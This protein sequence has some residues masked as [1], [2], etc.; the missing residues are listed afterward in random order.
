MSGNDGTKSQSARWFGGYQPKAT[1]ESAAYP[2]GATQHDILKDQLNPFSEIDKEAD[3]RALLSGDQLDESWKGIS[4][5]PDGTLVITYTYEETENIRE[6]MPSGSENKKETDFGPFEG[7]YL[8][9]MEET[10]QKYMP[11]TCNIRFEKNKNPE[12]AYLSIMTADLSQYDGSG[13]GGYA[14]SPNPDGAILIMNHKAMG[15]SPEWNK[16]T[17][18]HEL[19]HVAGLDHGFDGPYTLPSHQAN[20]DFSTMNYAPGKHTIHPQSF[21]TAGL[22]ALESM[23][24]KSQRLPETKTHVFPQRNKGWDGTLIASSG[25]DTIKF[26][27]SILNAETS[28]LIDLRAGTEHLSTFYDGK[29]RARNSEA[30]EVADVTLS[31]RSHIL[32]GAENANQ[33]LGGRGQ[34]FLQG[35]GGNDTISG[36]NNRD[37]IRMNAGDGHD[38]V[39]DYARND[40]I[41]YGAGIHA[42]HVTQN[43]GNTRINFTGL[44]PDK[45]VASAT[46][47]NFSGELGTIRPARVQTPDL[48][49]F[50]GDI[51]FKP[52]R[53]EE[54]G[55]RTY[56]RQRI[57]FP[58]GVKPH[59]MHAESVGE[60]HTVFDFKDQ[61][62]KSMGKVTV[63][64]NADPRGYALLAKSDSGELERFHV[65]VRVAGQLPLDDKSILSQGVDGH[66]M[67][68]RSA[69]SFQE[70]TRRSTY[71]HE[72]ENRIVSQYDSHASIQDDGFVYRGQEAR[73]KA[74]EF[75]TGHGGN[76]TLHTNTINTGKDSIGYSSW[77]G[78]LSA[79]NLGAEVVNMGSGQH[80]ILLQTFNDPE[81][82][83][84]TIFI[85]N[86]LTGDPRNLLFKHDGQTI[87]VKVSN[88]HDLPAMQQ[89]ELA[90]A[91]KESLARQ[92]SIEQELKFGQMI[93][94]G[95]FH[96]FQE[97]LQSKIDA[98]FEMHIPLAP[99]AITAEKGSNGLANLINKAE[100]QDMCGPVERCDAQF[101][102]PA[103]A[104]INTDSVPANLSPFQR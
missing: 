98:T 35:N 68:D 51:L 42:Y 59:S 10:L 23:Y 40:I 63:Y 37:F 41:E 81:N 44:R 8:R 46:L 53:N 3:Y 92:G 70:A 80:A 6:R 76:K 27:P 77:S 30:M 33:L 89:V 84:P 12:E 43:A 60:N 73:G 101:A 11:L 1:R 87:P 102:I 82:R 7:E 67:R 64:K 38:Q 97:T 15:R 25:V 34:S 93:D 56:S 66:F 22:K 91:A 21:Q 24:G 9:E 96:Q 31:T 54:V 58:R 16:S 100:F 36:G 86:E 20:E 83:Q 48:G 17:F 29:I 90:N 103:A 85:A 95:Q 78:D 61:N 13:A 52:G 79:E 14:S 28:S 45:V 26:D 55:F 4:R 65:P 99:K 5:D 32:I 88:L 62:K 69:L 74:F 104:A 19:G 71:V 18:I 50:T 39:L 2:A 94:K 57:V 47:K 49:G 75:N 72:S